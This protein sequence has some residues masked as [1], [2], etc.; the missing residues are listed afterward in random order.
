MLREKRPDDLRRAEKHLQA[1][2]GGIVGDLALDGSANDDISLVTGR[3]LD[4]TRPIGGAET[5]RGEIK[6]LDAGA[7]GSTG[8]VRG[9]VSGGGLAGLFGAGARD[10]GGR[11]GGSLAD[12]FKAGESFSFNF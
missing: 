11:G 3:Q 10:S 2:S 12:A 7:A 9:V 4:A 6:T 8:E 1:R 5:G